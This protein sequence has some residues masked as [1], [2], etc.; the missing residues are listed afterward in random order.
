MRS[1]SELN[2]AAG[3]EAGFVANGIAR[4]LANKNRRANLRIGSVSPQLRHGYQS[5]A[6]HA[7]SLEYHT[8]RQIGS[9]PPANE[10][11]A[12]TMR[13]AWVWLMRSPG[14]RDRTSTA[15]ARWHAPAAPF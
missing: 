7:L 15:T 8:S 2:A 5:I 9:E 12:L 13:R 6:A 4:S 3:R 14:G 1:R 10:V 11:A